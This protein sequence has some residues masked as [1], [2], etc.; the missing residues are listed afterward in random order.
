[1]FDNSS[2]TNRYTGDRVFCN[3]MNEVNAT[4]TKQLNLF[5]SFLSNKVV[6][7]VST[8]IISVCALS[9]TAGRFLQTYTDQLEEAR[10]TM[11]RLGERIETKKHHI[12][13]QDK[14]ITKLRYDNILLQDRI[15][16]LEDRLSRHL[17]NEKQH[18][19]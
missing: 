11:D 6:T 2:L 18:R 19:Y 17:T 14:E 12:S 3:F 7:L 1:M 5:D 10:R 15:T 4:G 16:R 9:F 8:T 13:R